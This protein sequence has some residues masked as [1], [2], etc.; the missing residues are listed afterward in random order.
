MKK[1]LALLLAVLMVIG[2]VACGESKPAET[3]GNNE[4]KPA[5]SKPTEVQD[6][7]LKVWAPQEDQVDGKGWL[8]EML[9]KF[10]AA[11]PEYKITW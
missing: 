5:E 7:T 4:S 9:A 3:Q 11:H 1:I 2:L 6:V 8:N 10:E